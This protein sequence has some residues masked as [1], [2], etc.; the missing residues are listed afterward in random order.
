M[1]TRYFCDNE[2]CLNHIFINME[3]F[4]LGE[5]NTEHYKR[6]KSTRILSKFGCF[7]YVMF[8]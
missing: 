3:E 1:K 4:I 5:I 8:V 7:F 6:I 2:K